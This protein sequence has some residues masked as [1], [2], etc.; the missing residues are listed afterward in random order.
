VLID[1]FTVVAQIINFVVLVALLKHFL[2][3]RLVKAV[4]EREK[5][6]AD[7]LSEAAEKK[8]EAEQQMEQAAARKLELDQSAVEMLALA[9]READQSRNAM[10]QESREEV[11]RLEAKWNEDL[12]R[13]RTAFLTELRQRAATELLAVTQR[14]LSDLACADVQHCAIEVFLEK[15]AELDAAALRELVGETVTV[16]T[17]IEL[18]EDTRQRIRK[19]LQERLPAP[20]SLQFVR[21][22]ALAWGIELRG[23][24]RRIGWSATSY[25]ETMEENLKQALERHAEVVVG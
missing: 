2:W 12:D 14:A 8:K 16:L 22:P 5:R 1:W 3:A 15:L 17:A 4:D 20:V 19:A 10:I 23:N 11:R 25:M 6:I 24:G 7:R 21:A 13:D 18:P 9:Q